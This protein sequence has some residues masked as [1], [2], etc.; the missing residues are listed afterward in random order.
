[1]TRELV[2]TEC[3]E[4]CDWVPTD[5]ISDGTRIFVCTGCKSEW[6]STQSWTPRNADGDIAAAVAAEVAAKAAGTTPVTLASET[7]TEGLGGGG[8]GGW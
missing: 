3:K 4:T 1:M 2:T 6:A 8:A 5:E 7:P